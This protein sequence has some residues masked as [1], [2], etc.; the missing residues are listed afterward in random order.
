M[1]F[2]FRSCVG[3]ISAGLGR[4]A[5]YGWG[6]GGQLLYLLPAIDM[7]VVITSDPDT[8]SGRTGYVDELHGLVAEI[9]RT[10]T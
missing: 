6:Y 4:P 9:V 2:S 10:A 3:L 8:P 5:V 7:V 1:F